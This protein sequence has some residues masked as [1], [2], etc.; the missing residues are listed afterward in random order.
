MQY[1]ATTVKFFED[2]AVQHMTHSHGKDRKIISYQKRK[3][4]IALAEAP[5]MTIKEAAK[6]RACT[7]L[8][9]SISSRNFDLAATLSPCRHVGKC[10]G[11]F[12]LDSSF[13]SGNSH[14]RVGQLRALSMESQYSRAPAES[15]VRATRQACYRLYRAGK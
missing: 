3:E 15:S 4:L 8:R 13:R 6:K 11:T 12:E 5:N 9:R 10:S 2:L 14:P 1:A 7:T